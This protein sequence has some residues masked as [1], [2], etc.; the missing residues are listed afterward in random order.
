MPS[1]AK[2]E[3]FSSRLGHFSLFDSQHFHYLGSYF[4]YKVFIFHYKISFII[5]KLVNMSLRSIG[6]LISKLFLL[7]NHYR[8]SCGSHPSPFMEYR[9]YVC[10]SKARQYYFETNIWIHLYGSKYFACKKLFF[11]YRPT[12][13]FEMLAI[14][15]HQGNKIF[16][17]T[18][19]GKHIRFPLIHHLF[20]T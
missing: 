5:S 18:C 20:G 3:I 13:S 1:A 11:Y 15:A 7:L 19:V 6:L 16:N 12:G 2:K 14:F 10:L 9:L 8:I 17:W 4:I